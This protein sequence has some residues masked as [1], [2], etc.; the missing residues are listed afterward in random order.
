M[1]GSQ[2]CLTQGRGGR[3]L[4]RLLV[5]LPRSLLALGGAE[6][7][8]FAPGARFSCGGLTD[9]ALVGRL[10]QHDLHLDQLSLVV[11]HVL[12]ERA[13]GVVGAV[14]LLVD[15]LLGEVLSEEAG[16]GGG[17]DVLGGEAEDV[18]DLLASI[19]AGEL[20]NLEG[21]EAITVGSLKGKWVPMDHSKSK[22]HE[23]VGV[24]LAIAGNLVEK[25]RI[26]VFEHFTNQFVIVLIEELVTVCIRS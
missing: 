12:D 11:L 15:E 17:G 13:S 18:L 5:L 20:S 9:V 10:L 4:A 8:G 3:R 24:Y 25:I 21:I 19:A 23:G 26:V 7:A 14:N 1:E 22:K 16:E 6:V 2:F